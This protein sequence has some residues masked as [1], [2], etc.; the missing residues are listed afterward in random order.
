M[1]KSSHN[2]ISSGRR[3]SNRDCNRPALC[4]VCREVTCRAIIRGGWR[5]EQRVQG[6]GS[7]AGV[8]LRLFIGGKQLADIQEQVISAFF[9]RI[10]QLETASAEFR[11]AF[12]A[13]VRRQHGARV[14]ELAALFSMAPKTPDVPPA[15]PAE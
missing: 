3:D 13:E 9:E 14:P 15:R 10:D 4:R 8:A 1:E 12:E 11:A 5:S 6:P 7:L 2:D